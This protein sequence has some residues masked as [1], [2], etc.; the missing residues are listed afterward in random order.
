[1]SSTPSYLSHL[2]KVLLSCFAIVLISQILSSR[3]LSLDGAHNLLRMILKDSFYQLEIAR[4]SFCFLKQFPAFLFIKLKL[5]DSISLLTQV[6]SFGLVYIHIFSFIGAYLILPHD[7]KQFLFFPLLAFFLGPITALGVSISASLSVCSYLWF[8][9]FTIHYSNLSL[10]KH[11]ITLILSPLPLFLS[12]ELMSYMAW[13]LIAL[14]VL[15]LK[16]EKEPL[17]RFLLMAV[18]GCLIVIS[19][20]SLFLFFFPNLSEL[21]NR[22]EFIDS[23]LKLEFFF[24]MKQGHL[25]WIYPACGLSF[26]L[27]LV[28]F[29][30]AIV[31]KNLYKPTLVCVFFGLIST[32]MLSVIYPFYELFGI[33][34]LTTEEEARVWASC[35]ALP[36]SFLLWWLFEKE[37]L[38]WKK[39]L[40]IATLIA[41]ISL[42]IWRVGSDYRFYRYQKQ[43]S[44][45]LENFKGL[46][47]WQDF[48]DDN[49]NRNLIY[50]FHWVSYSL[51]F[52]KKNSI[53]ALVV[54]DKKLY[55]GK[56]PKSMCQY[57]DLNSISE[58]WLFNL[59][60]SLTA[61]SDTPSSKP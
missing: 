5:S 45:K 39:S 42:T 57:P 27:F 43:F 12:H 21:P 13:P 14:S 28:P 8:Q 16:N 46:V 54:S 61:I 25:Q 10:K 49:M 32:C 11:Q 33:F 47:S 40:F 55:T 17:N 31:R 3:G 41:A 36:S 1:M 15:K 2:N 26:F 48:K 22:K 59:D 35:I 60:P 29:L 4:T 23:L 7:K 37:K 19:I 9:A 18:S 30:Q 56:C 58:T 6:F 20:L 51:L 34:K 44:N 24:K 38:K 52:P 53:T 50:P